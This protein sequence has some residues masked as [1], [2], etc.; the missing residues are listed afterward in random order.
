MNSSSSLQDTQRVRSSQNADYEKADD[1]RLSQGESHHAAQRR[2]AQQ[3]C[4]LIEHG[5]VNHFH[6]LTTP[7]GPDQK[8]LLHPHG[9]WTP[10]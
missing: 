3:R 2:K 10:A 6:S 1:Q 9:F 5:L 4:N 7:T 8:L